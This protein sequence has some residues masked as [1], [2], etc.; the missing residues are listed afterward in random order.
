MRPDL[1]HVGSCSFWTSHVPYRDFSHGPFCQTCVHLYLGAQWPK[2]S[3]LCPYFMQSACS[4]WHHC[5]LCWSDGLS[6]YQKG[7]TPHPDPP[8]MNVLS[9]VYQDQEVVHPMWQT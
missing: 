3:V 1:A 5:P 9:P 2:L 4:T 8:P 6:N 7:W